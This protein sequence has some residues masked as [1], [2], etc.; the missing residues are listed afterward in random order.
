MLFVLFIPSVDRR[1]R[2]IDHARWVDEA[3]TV[4]ASLFRGATAYPR[5]LGQWR[6]DELPFSHRLGRETDQGEVGLVVDSAYYP[7][8][9]FDEEE[10][11]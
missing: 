5:G 1:G 9:R 3:L 2:P 10:R 11:S 6:D 4:L 7:I 8:T